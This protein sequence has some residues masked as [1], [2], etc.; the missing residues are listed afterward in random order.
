MVALHI[1]L[2]LHPE[3]GTIDHEEAYN[4]TQATLAAWVEPRRVLALQYLPFC[5]GCSV[6]GLLGHA[7]FSVFGASILAW[8]IVPALFHAI[9]LACAARTTPHPVVLLAMIMVPPVVYLNGAH[10]YGNHYEAGWLALGVLAASTTAT[11]PGH[12][13][14]LALTASF[15]CWYALSSSWLLVAVAT[16]WI[17]ERRWTLVVVFTLVC[18]TMLAAWL[19]VGD[20]ARDL[21]S[22]TN[23]LQLLPAELGGLSGPASL[24]ERVSSWAISFSRFSPHGRAPFGWLALLMAPLTM[25][26]LARNRQP[27]ELRVLLAAGACCAAMWWS[28]F[29]LPSRPDNPFAARYAIHIAQILSLAVGLTSAGLLERGRVA[30]A[31][32]LLMFWSAPAIVGRAEL[33][34]RSTT[35]HLMHGQLVPWMQV[36]RTQLSR[37]VMT[38]GSWRCQGDPRCTYHDHYRRGRALASS[39]CRQHPVPCGPCDE[40]AEL[41]WHHGVAHGL[42]SCQKEATPCGRFVATVDALGLDS[43]ATLLA[44][45]A[46]VGDSGDRNEPCSPVP[47]LQGVLDG[48]RPPAHDADRSS[49]SAGGVSEAS[50]L[51]QRF[52]LDLRYGRGAAL[53][54]TPW[55]VPELELG[56]APES[57]PD[58]VTP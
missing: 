50:A 53:G 7:V 3:F 8:K 1:G 2:L 14:G 23:Y 16:A 46:G 4:V 35:M 47:A 57:E 40:D 42:A 49:L 28:P 27:L 30:P 5:N 34:P 41:G 24:L 26:W 39:T 10:A 43:P 6:N 15:I 56:L 54:P 58:G 45:A 37:R 20:G 9:A 33:I 55:R 52:Q 13:A 51:L 38:E 19:T 31:M 21:R 32:A 48:A 29:D 44:A 11:K 17:L 12:A 36:R 22:L 25:V 18:L